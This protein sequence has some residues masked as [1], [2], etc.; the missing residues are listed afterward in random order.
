MGCKA[1]VGFNEETSV[2]FENLSYRQTFIECDN[3]ALKMF[4]MMSDVSIGHAFNA[5]KNYYTNRIDRA[6]EFG[7][8]IVFTSF[9]RENR[10]ALICLGNKNLKKEDLFLS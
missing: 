9:L 5:M 10:D 3:F 7:E 6:M 2:I 1:F 4:M 8:D